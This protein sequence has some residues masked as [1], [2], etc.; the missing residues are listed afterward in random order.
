MSEDRNAKAGGGIG[1]CGILGIVLIALRVAG[2][3]SWPWI[4]VLA[5]LWVPVAACAV[6]WLAM[7]IMAYRSQ[8]RREGR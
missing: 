8:K 1:F 4:W 6:L 7:F 3:I 2:V 5:P